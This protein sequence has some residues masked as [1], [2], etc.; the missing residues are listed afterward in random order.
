M[1]H[2]S[3]LLNLG[4]Y[5]KPQIYIQ[6]DKIQVTWGHPGLVAEVQSRDNFVELSPVT[7]E[8][9]TNSKQ[10]MSELNWIIEYP[11]G[12]RELNQIDIV[13]QLELTLKPNK[14]RIHI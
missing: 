8:I 12:V 1:S 13:K 2:S 7:S 10:L 3:K 6:P 14:T 11:D 5:G 9:C 4:G